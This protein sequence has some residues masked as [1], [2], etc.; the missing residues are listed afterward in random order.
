MSGGLIYVSFIRDPFIPRARQRSKTPIPSY[1]MSASCSI[2]VRTMLLLKSCER[3]PMRYHTT[4]ET[5][6]D[7]ARYTKL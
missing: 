6:A 4:R 7:A 3:A 5:L 1:S 2:Y